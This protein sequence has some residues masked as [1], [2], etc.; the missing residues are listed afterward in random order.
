MLVEGQTG[1]DDRGDGESEGEDEQKSGER[2]P[3]QTNVSRKA[4]EMAF[5]GDGRQRCELAV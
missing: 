5:D 4:A 2:D 3:D 1:D